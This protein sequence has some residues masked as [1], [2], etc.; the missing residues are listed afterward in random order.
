MAT[1]TVPIKH[2]TVVGGGVMGSGIA[3]V[4][5]ANGY[6][7]TVVDVNDDVLASAQR[8]LEKNLKRTA[9]HVT[10]GDAEAAQTFFA[11][12]KA[13]LSFSTDLKQTVSSTDLVIEAIVEK[14][15]A[16]QNLFSI[17]DQ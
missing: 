13:R 6:R 8:D 17:V 11:E 1:S 5:A 10:K 12:A 4:T 7:V 3:L 9:M 2:V 16:K 15:D 14:L